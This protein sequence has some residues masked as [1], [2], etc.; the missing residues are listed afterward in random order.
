MSSIREA[1]L[2]GSSSQWFAGQ[3]L[4]LRAKRMERMEVFIIEHGD[5]PAVLGLDLEMVLTRLP[6]V[7]YRAGRERAHRELRYT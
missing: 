6:L 4:E 1:D 5:P 7:S 3:A 2:I